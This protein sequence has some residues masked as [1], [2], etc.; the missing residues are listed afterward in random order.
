MLTDS[1]EQNAVLHSEADQAHARVQVGD[2]V[3][4]C[5]CACVC[6][7]VRV[8][9]RVCVCVFEYV[10]ACASVLSLMCTGVHT[11]VMRCCVLQLMSAADAAIQ[12]RATQWCCSSCPC[13]CYSCFTV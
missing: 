12:C 3:C 2:C 7:C 10:R 6:V 8:C 1:K 5:V 13:R 9:V 4:V 11:H